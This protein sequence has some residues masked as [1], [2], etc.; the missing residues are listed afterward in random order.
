MELFIF[1]FFGFIFFNA[2]TSGNKK[3][4]KKR[5]NHAERMKELAREMSSG[6]RPVPDN[7]KFFISQNESKNTE[8]RSRDTSKTQSKAAAKAMA[9]MLAR[10]HGVADLNRARRRDWGVRGH[11]PLYSFPNLI[12]LGSVIYILSAIF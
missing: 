3:T 8:I 4:K 11:A 5:Q 1:L 7:L 6:E 12:G 2:I 10:R 9:Q